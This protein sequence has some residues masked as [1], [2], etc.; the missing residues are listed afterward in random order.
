MLC[1]RFKHNCYFPPVAS[2]LNYTVYILRVRGMQLKSQ[3]Y[4]CLILWNCSLSEISCAALV[5]VL[6]SNP[7]HLRELDLSFN[8][9]EDSG[10]KRLC[11]GLESPNCRLETLRLWNCSLSEISCAALVSALKFNPSHLRELDLSFNNLED[12]G[13]K[14]LCDFLES[15]NCRLETLRSVLVFCSCTVEGCY[16]VETIVDT[17]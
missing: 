13:V 11:A 6:K 5:S 14:L 9:L 2:F 4:L 15:P 12:S 7:S 8:N 10:V 1:I 3:K 17:E 16:N